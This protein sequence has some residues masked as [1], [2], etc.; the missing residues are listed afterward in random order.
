MTATWQEFRVSNDCIMD[1]EELRR[2]LEEAGY[3]FFKRL[4]NRDKLLAVRKDMTRVLHAGG[5]LVADADPM[6]GIADITHRCTRIS[7]ITREAPGL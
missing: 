5:W 6:L 7:C 2:R 3:L 1:A 4:Q